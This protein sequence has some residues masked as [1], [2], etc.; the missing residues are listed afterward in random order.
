MP[1]LAASAFS[2]VGPAASASAASSRAPISTERT[3]WRDVE[4]GLFMA[5]VRC[6]EISNALCNVKGCPH[7]RPW[8]ERARLRQRACRVG[9]RILQAGAPH[10]G[11]RLQVGGGGLAEPA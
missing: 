10:R 4:F 7:V 11:A 2:G 5:P 6:Y 9:G 3:P 1:A 8:Q